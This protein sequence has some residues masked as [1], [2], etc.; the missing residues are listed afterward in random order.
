[1]KRIVAAQPPRTLSDIASTLLTVEVP[2]DDCDATGR[3]T[4]IKTNVLNFSSPYEYV[5]QSC[6]TCF[7]RGLREAE[8][9]PLCRQEENGCQRLC[10][11]TICCQK[12]PVNCECANGIELYA[13]ALEAAFLEEASVVELA[14]A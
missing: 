12:H 9:C 8:I 14:F 1:M 4:A 13:L 3:Q 6:A 11:P 5:R 2:C 7:G 10:K